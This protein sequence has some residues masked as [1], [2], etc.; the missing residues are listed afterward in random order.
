MNDTDAIIED[1][2]PLKTQYIPSEFADRDDLQNT[3]QSLIS[4]AEETGSRNLLIHGPPGS[5]KTH[6]VQAH[7]KDTPTT[8]NTCYIPCTHCKTQYQALKQLYHTVTDETVN[9]GHHTADLKR[10][11]EERTHATSPIVVLDDID[12]LLQN[13]GNDLLY[14]LS[15]TNDIN[16]I[17]ISTKRQSL[18]DTI[19]ERTRS[20]LQPQPIPMEP[21]TPEDIYQILLQRAQDALKPQSLHREALTYIASTTT[22]TS[23]ALHWLKT[24]AEQA[25]QTITE[26]TV[27]DTRE[28]GRRKYID[29]LLHPFTDH[30]QLLYQA[31]QE[32][33]EET[34][35]ETIQTGAVYQRY[36]EL[37]KTY[38]EEPLS[39]RRISDYIKHLELLQLIKAD[40]HYGGTKGKT[41]EIRVNKLF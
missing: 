21:Y 7:L 39:N 30:H 28:S 12:F 38:N 41:R 10:E 5:G 2:A 4:Q 35:S 22:N 6:L 15:R 9:D 29:E 17:L 11:I 40:Y 23:L 19:E 24:A 32:L 1:F 3:L 27:K 16:T 26:N 8:V 14:Y 33:T 13:D 20:S 25:S 36:Q 37:C 34:D 18:E 31:I